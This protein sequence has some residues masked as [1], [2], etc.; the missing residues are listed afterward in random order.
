[1]GESAIPAASADAI[2]SDSQKPYEKNTIIV[3]KL[4]R[5]NRMGIK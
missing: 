2:R 4:V 5:K 3:F 1:M